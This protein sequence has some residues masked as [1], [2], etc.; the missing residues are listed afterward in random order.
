MPRG[1]L[2]R[3]NKRASERLFGR[4]PAVTGLK[5]EI[6][7]D[8]A[9]G[10]RIKMTLTNMSIT[11]TD[12]LAYASK[13]LLDFPAGRLQIIGGVASLA[14]AVSSARAG[15]INADAAMDWSIGTA[16]ASN[17]TLD[18]TMV[19]IVAKQDKTLDG[20]NAA[21]T[22]AQAANLAA[23]AFFDG[24]GTAK[25]AYLNVSFPTATEIDADGTL[26]VTGTIE[27]HVRNLG[28]V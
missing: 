28:D 11:V 13:K 24:T 6:T 15:T 2:S 20:V 10:Y 7:G 25:D 22:T 8:G 26:L 12:A 9:G 23:T 4:Q 18:T 1:H 5:R 14:F 21:F 27:M 17:V 19:D 16:A 3:S